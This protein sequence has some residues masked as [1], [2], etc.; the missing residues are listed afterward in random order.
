MSPSDVSVLTAGSGY[1]SRSR[2]MQFAEALQESD[3]Q[4]KVTALHGLLNL[5]GWRSGSP[6]TV[7]STVAACSEI[8]TAQAAMLEHTK[9]CLLELRHEVAVV[10]SSV[11]AGITPRSVSTAN[12]FAF[13]EV[14]GTPLATEKA[15]A[16]R[17][18]AQKSVK[19]LSDSMAS[20]TGSQ[21][22]S[23]ITRPTSLTA[24]MRALVNPPGGLETSGTTDSVEFFSQEEELYESSRA[25]VESA[26]AEARDMRDSRSR[27]VREIAAMFEKSKATEGIAK[28][29]KHRRTQTLSE[30]KAPNMIPT[31][32][33]GRVGSG[34]AFPSFPVDTLTR[35]LSENVEP[36]KP[37]LGSPPNKIESQEEALSGDEDGLSTLQKNFGVVAGLQ[38]ETSFKKPPPSLS[39]P[40]PQSGTAKAD[41]EDDGDGSESD[42]GL[43][44]LQK[45]FGVTPGI[46]R[47][48]SQSVPAEQQNAAKGRAL[49]IDGKAPIEEDDEDDGMSPLQRSFGYVAGLGPRGSTCVIPAPLP[50]KKPAQDY[51]YPSNH[52][53]E[54]KAIADALPKV[55]MI[56][57]VNK[58]KKSRFSIKG[59][60]RHKH[61]MTASPELFQAQDMN[62]TG[63]DA[64]KNF[65]LKEDR[66]AA[67][68]ALKNR[69]NPIY[70]PGSMESISQSFDFDECGSPT[71]SSTEAYK[72]VYKDWMNN[73]DR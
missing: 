23:G 33:E 51:S 47:R 63:E 64:A 61:A 65:G 68:P 36:R 8:I 72:K 43:S 13:D 10:R 42:D 54:L 15:K 62:G 31:V 32:Q 52:L 57:K 49:S 40:H 27:S 16:N 39:P 69:D 66:K 2:T 44:P 71:K 50:A 11:E 45:G 7:H 73:K 48:I 60:G 46:A 35:S 41:L 38:K 55:P 5:P 21:P 19:K 17:E 26:L 67:Y 4:A 56:A 1:S 9:E 24:A 29:E 58:M 20:M 14:P 70:S 28:R 37:K 25:G 34:K 22:S 59:R 53:M 18:V 30:R 12:T 3:L 6:S